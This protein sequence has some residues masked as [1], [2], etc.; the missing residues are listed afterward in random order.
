MTVSIRLPRWLNV[1]S[2]TLLLASIGYSIFHSVMGWP[3]GDEAD[4]LLHARLLAEGKVP[5]L[6][7]HAIIPPLGQLLTAGVIKLVG[8]NVPLIRSVILLGWVTQIVVL[9]R[10]AREFLPL[11]WCWTLAAFLWL[12]DTRYLVNQHHFW[13]GLFALLAIVQI[14]QYL[15]HRQSKNLLWGG[16]W[17]GL[18]P[19]VTQSLGGLIILTT[20][21]FSLLDRKNWFRTWGCYWLLPVLLVALGMMGWVWSMGAWDG[22]LRDAVF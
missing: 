20:L 4:Y 13:S 8:L 18:V 10:L 22:F 1:V 6:D 15:Q 3:K 2:L 5:Y 9:F 11:S 7:F 12:S 16:I 17:M 19:W 21:G 14:Y